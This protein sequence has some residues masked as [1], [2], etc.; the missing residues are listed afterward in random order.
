[1][2]SIGRPE[3]AAASMHVARALAA[4]LDQSPAVREGGKVRH[5]VL[6]RLGEA[7]A[8][9]RSGELDRII[10][11]LQAHAEGRW[12]PA[13]RLAAETAPRSVR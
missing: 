4:S 10:A 7:G 13:D 11:A 8:L 2:S 6:F 1:M 12:V 3:V 5:R 9:R